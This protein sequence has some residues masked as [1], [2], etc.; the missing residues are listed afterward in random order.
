MAHVNFLL[1]FL[2][3]ALF[4]GILNPSAAKAR[5]LSESL[6]YVSSTYSDY[7]DLKIAGG[8]KVTISPTLDVEIG[9]RFRKMFNFLINAAQTTDHTREEY[10]L[11]LKVDLPGFFWMGVGYGDFSREAKNYPVNSSVFLSSQLT[12]IT[13]VPDDDDNKSLST[14]LGITVDIFLFNP[15]TFLTAS[16]YVYTFNG[17]SFLGTR[18]GLGAQF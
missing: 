4:S 1:T 14:K 12:T 10:G 15:L 7:E 8:D 3:L 17:N 18:A 13:S 9:L 11:G 16:A 5:G 2:I 6:L